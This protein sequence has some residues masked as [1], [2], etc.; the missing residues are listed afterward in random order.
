MGTDN[1]KE[2]DTW[3]SPERLLKKYKIIVLE[4]ENDELEELIK[5]SK[6]LSYLFVD[7]SYLR[8]L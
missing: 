7:K 4:R 2:V 6:L 8:F 1:L 5:N 3:N